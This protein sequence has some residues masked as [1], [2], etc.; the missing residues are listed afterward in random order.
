[1][2][3]IPGITK[4]YNLAKCFQEKGVPKLFPGKIRDRA[5]RTCN[6]GRA[7]HGLLEHTYP[8]ADPISFHPR[9]KEAKEK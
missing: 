4:W 9:N 3:L 7:I 6:Y 5:I 1:M 8:E 2:L